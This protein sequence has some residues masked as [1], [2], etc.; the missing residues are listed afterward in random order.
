ML[1]KLPS[2]R[3]SVILSEAW[4]PISEGDFCYNVTQN[5]A[6][7]RLGTKFITKTVE[8]CIHCVNHVHVRQK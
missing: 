4:V 6:I 1:D 5:S 7:R 8:L 3:L 2:L